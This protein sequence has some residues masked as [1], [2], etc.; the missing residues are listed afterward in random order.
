MKSKILFALLFIAIAISAY[1]TYDRT[2]VRNDFEI[3][4]SEEL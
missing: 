3:F 4:N 1:L 2:I